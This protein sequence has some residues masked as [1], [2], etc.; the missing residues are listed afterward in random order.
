MSQTDMRKALFKSLNEANLGGYSIQW[1]N[2]NFVQPDNASWIKVMIGFADSRST[3]ISHSDLI[4]GQLQIYV[5]CPKGDGDITA[6]QVHSS[7]KTALP[8]KGSSVE[9]N[10]QKVYIDYIRMLGERPDDSGK[11]A[12]S[13]H[14]IQIAF[15]GSISQ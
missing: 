12:F 14:L 7:L 8:S 13:K 15:N 6:F 4:R 3:T 1:P 5:Y 2:A 10:G 11:Q 9:Y